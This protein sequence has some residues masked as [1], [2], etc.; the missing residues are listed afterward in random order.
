MADD[1]PKNITILH[2][3]VGPSHNLFT[4]GQVV[5]ADKFGH[6]IMDHGQLVFY[7]WDLQ[8]LLDLGAVAYTDEPASENLGEDNGPTPE[9]VDGKKAPKGGVKV[10]EDGNPIMPTEHNQEP[11]VV[12]DDTDEGEKSTGGDPP[13][14]QQSPP[15][16]L[17]S[18]TRKPK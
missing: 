15:A 17:P 1:K 12:G 2:D 14:S 7:E 5:P 8:R 13:H 16:V 18:T 6:H 4:K 9:V 3:M 11:P 10:D